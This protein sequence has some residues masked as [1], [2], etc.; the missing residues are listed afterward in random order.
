MSDSDFSMRLRMQCLDLATRV[1]AFLV[2]MTASGERREDCVDRAQRYYEFVMGGP[3]APEA[4]VEGKTLAEWA[5]VR[6]GEGR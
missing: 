3:S 2:T 5:G 4:R 1:G 6:G